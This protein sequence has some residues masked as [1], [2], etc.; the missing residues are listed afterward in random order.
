MPE[1]R[2]SEIEQLKAQ[3]AELKELVRGGGNIYQVPD[4]IK[5]LSEFTGNKKELIIW[6]D[7]VDQLY[8]SFKIKGENGSPDTMNAY[9]V[10]AIK[11][12]IKGEARVTLC[13]NGNPST[14]PEI[15]RVLMQHYGDRRDIAT[16]LNLLFTLKKGDRSHQ[17]F[18]NEM[19]ELE[20]R[21]NSNLQLNPLTAVQLL[22][23]I[24]ITKY[25]DNISEP[26]ASIIRSTNPSNIEEAFQAVTLNQNAE[27][28][29]P[30][31]KS[32]SQSFKPN[33]NNKNSTYIPKQ[34]AGPSQQKTTKQPFKSP[35]T[36]PKQ[37]VEVNTNLV[38]SDEESDYNDHSNVDDDDN[39][40]NEHEID[41]ATQLDELNF[42]T[43]KLKNRQT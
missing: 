9:Y 1:T 14:I 17:K 41:D 5:Q 38:Q 34:D 18:F 35:Y 27:I 19:K 24:V 12:K 43:V 22:Q 3:V 32:T 26:L 10:Q 11:N 15:K 30:F 21:I 7:E 25:L 16:N 4:P 36:R 31:V 29:K 42:Q 28:R 23:K 6:L 37:R 33:S 2:T 40:D 8:S 39:D 13:A 20:M